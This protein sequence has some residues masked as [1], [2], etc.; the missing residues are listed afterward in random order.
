MS[1]ATVSIPFKQDVDIYTE[2]DWLTLQLTFYSDTA[3]TTVVD[4]SASTFTGEVLDKVSGTKL[5]DLSFN[6][7]ANDGVI[8]PKLT[9]TETA[10][11]TGKTSHYFV[12]VTTGGL[13]S[14]YFSGRITVAEDFKAGA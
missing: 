5:A 2:M 3:Q 14:P 10:L 9:D 12:Y 1:S 11:L 7:P 13:K 6:T 8:W 4:Y